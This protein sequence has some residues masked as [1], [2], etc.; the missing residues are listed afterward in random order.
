[1][2]LEEVIPIDFFHNFFFTPKQK[3]KKGKKKKKPRFLALKVN[4]NHTIFF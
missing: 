2:E 4:I 1:V 3:Q